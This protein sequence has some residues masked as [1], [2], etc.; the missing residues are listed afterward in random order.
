MTSHVERVGCINA[1]G[2]SR[3]RGENGTTLARSRAAVMSSYECQ[4]GLHRSAVADQAT[5]R[6]QRPSCSAACP[7]IQMLPEWGR[8]KGI[9]RH[10]AKS[11]SWRQ[12]QPRVQHEPAMVTRAFGM[13]L[14]STVLTAVIALPNLFVAAPFYYIDTSTTGF[15]SA[16]AVGDLNLDGYV[17]VVANT[18]PSTAFDFFLSNGA[19]TPSWS[20]ISVTSVGRMSTTCV[21]D[22]DGDGFVDVFGAS[23]G[24][25]KWFRNDGNSVPGFATVFTL[26]AYTTS[27]LQCV[28]VD[29]DGTMDVFV[30]GL[31]WFT[32]FVAYP[33]PSWTFNPVA[34]L[35]STVTRV[36]DVDGD[37]VND[38]VVVGSQLTWC[39]GVVG[40][41]LPPTI[42]WLSP[43]T[44]DTSPLVSSSW[45]DDVNGDGITD[46]LI[47]RS[48]ATLAWYT[49]NGT[50][51]ALTALL[52]T[53]TVW[54]SFSTGDFDQD[55][56]V[57][58]MLCENTLS[59]MASLESDGGSPPTFTV[60]FIHVGNNYVNAYAAVAADVDND[61]DLDA[62][63][64]SNAG[65]AW[66]ANSLCPVG[67]YSP[68]TGIAPCSLCPV[69]TYG[70]TA[71]LTTAQCSG[72]CPAGK[73]SNKVTGA[74]ACV[75]CPVGTFGNVTG[76]FTPAC[77]GVCTPDPNQNSTCG[78][79]EVSALGHAGA[80]C[81]P[82]T[83]LPSNS[84]QTCSQCPVGRYGDVPGLASSDCAGPCNS[85]AGSACSLGSTSTCTPRW[86]L[87]YPKN[88]GRYYHAASCSF[89]VTII[90]MFK[91]LPSLARR[92][93]D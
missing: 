12:V 23:T 90:T 27:S 15:P 22:A 16:I 5:Q 91:L 55:G 56:D 18:N 58:V 81:P 77:S 40:A 50:G 78:L 61:G 66:Y 42:T 67:K 68:I 71:G 39:R 35:A 45:L 73:F 30:G 24:W 92:L 44:I 46:I 83:Y 47:G 84:T 60:G 14:L 93:I 20:K 6:R 57:D 8:A 51:F 74:T 13:I 33:I 76:L 88:T 85:S 75:S 52:T 10:L 64:D 48:S 32:G 26:S 19:T 41:S 28:D 29:G 59:S 34:G 54:L 53:G 87:S 69:G 3:R 70:A 7:D 4:W 11:Q 82:G 37:G 31:G 79:N 62:I 65:L 49:Y 1:S 9:C 38:L 21:M 2:P 25:V 43:V 17:D 89:F 86:N 36:G 63:G 80:S 72:P